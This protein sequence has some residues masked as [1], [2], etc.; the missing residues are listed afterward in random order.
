MVHVGSRTE[1]RDKHREF[2]GFGPGEA[3]QPV[4]ATDDHRIYHLLLESRHNSLEEKTPV[5][6]MVSL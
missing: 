3:S 5:A 2:P 6:R 1:Q 4:A